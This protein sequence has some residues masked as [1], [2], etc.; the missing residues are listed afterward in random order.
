MH[1][2]PFLLRSVLFWLFTSPYQIYVLTCALLLA[3][4]YLKVSC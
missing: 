3:A 4:E 2:L 1:I